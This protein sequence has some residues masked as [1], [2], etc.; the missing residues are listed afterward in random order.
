VKLPTHARHAMQLMLEVARRPDVPTSLREVAERTR[1]SR[2]CLDQLAIRLRNANLIRGRSGHGGGY[3]LA[4]PPAQ[5]SLGGIIEAASGPIHIVECLRH[6]ELCLQSDLCPCR[7]VYALM[8]ERI[9][10][11]LQGL[12]LAEFQ[13]HGGTVSAPG[14]GHPVTEHQLGSSLP[15][16]LLYLRS[17]R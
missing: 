8:N 9:R 12:S 7:A 5:I 10:E 15:T 14:E 16:S 13:A 2:R 1:V 17:F 11:A 3:R 4:R 6:P